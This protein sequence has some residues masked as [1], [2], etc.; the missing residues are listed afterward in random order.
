MDAQK[1]RL[2][3]M[4]LLS[5]FNI[6]FGGEIRKLIFTHILSGH[7]DIFFT[8]GSSSAGA[9]AMNSESETDEADMGRLQGNAYIFNA[10][11]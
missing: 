1:N 8:A 4:V 5:T 10:S 3:K 9:T 2:I 11:L 6:C 7:D